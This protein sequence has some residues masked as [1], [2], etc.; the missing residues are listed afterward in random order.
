MSYHNRLVELYAFLQEF[1]LRLKIYLLATFGHCAEDFLVV[2]GWCGDS[3][4]QITG[5]TFVER[6]VVLGELWQ[7]DIVQGSKT[8]LVLGPVELSEQKT[9]SSENS[10]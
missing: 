2:R 6:D 10:L 3:G 7:V 4:E 9:A 1:L 5:D 8:D